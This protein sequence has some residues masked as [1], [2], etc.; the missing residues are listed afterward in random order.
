MKE[1]RYDE[2]RKRCGFV[3]CIP[4]LVFDKTE[5]LSALKE[6]RTNAY[7]PVWALEACCVSTIADQ[8]GPVKAW[9]LSC[10]GSSSSNRRTTSALMPRP[11]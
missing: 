9:F 7:V 10:R 8:L 3:G 11:F 1:E 2:L 5:F 4:R 6:L